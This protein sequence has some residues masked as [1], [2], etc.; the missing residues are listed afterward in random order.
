MFL[1]LQVLQL[2]HL[3]G[4]L[5]HRLLPDC[6]LLP[7]P[8]LLPAILS[9]WMPRIRLCNHFRLMPLLLRSLPL[10]PLLRFRLFPVLQCFLRLPGIYK[11]NLHIPLHIRLTPSIRFRLFLT[12]T[13]NEENRLSQAGFPWIYAS[14]YLLQ[15]WFHSLQGLLY[16]YCHFHNMSNGL[17]TFWLPVHHSF[18]LSL[19]VRIHHKNHLLFLLLVRFLLQLLMRYLLI[20]IHF[21]LLLLQS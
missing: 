5:P 3:S 4:W 1:L 19:L 20:R 17:H 16:K 18:H 9:A 6:V 2:L 10:I 12:V 7:V 21:R 8:L 13:G 11:C 14:S 15:I